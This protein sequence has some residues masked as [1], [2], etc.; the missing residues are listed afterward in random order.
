[1][2][3]SSIWQGDL[4]G[5]HHGVAHL[6]LG[7]YL[8]NQLAGRASRVHTVRTNYAVRG[9]ETTCRENGAPID[10]RVPGRAKF[11]VLHSK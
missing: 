8:V 10:F 5:C 2:F 3:N 6:F 4:K 11:L 7:N 9:N 1:M